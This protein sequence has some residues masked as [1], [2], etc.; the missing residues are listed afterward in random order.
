L[1]SLNDTLPVFRKSKSTL[2]M[3]FGQ[4]GVCK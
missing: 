1:T 3:F 4:S 2:H